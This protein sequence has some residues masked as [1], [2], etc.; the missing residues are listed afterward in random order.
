MASIQELE[1]NNV[2]YKKVDNIEKYIKDPVICVGVLFAYEK[3]ERE[4]FE[5]CISVA[6]STK[7]M[8]IIFQTN[9]A[10]FDYFCQ[11]EYGCP[12]EAAYRLILEDAVSDYK[13]ALQNLAQMGNATAMN[14]VNQIVLDSF[15]QTDMNV[16]IYA[17]IPKE[18]K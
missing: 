12:F 3:L 9:Y 13:T 14:T 18:E 7:N 10:G 11:K 2:V 6:T 8:C 1:Q 15:K 16:T 4:K 5:N 17:N